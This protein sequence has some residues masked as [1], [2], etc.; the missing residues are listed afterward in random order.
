MTYHF[1]RDSEGQLFMGRGTLYAKKARYISGRLIQ[2]H[3]VTREAVKWQAEPDFEE[4]VNGWEEVSDGR[5]LERLGGGDVFKL[6]L[7]RPFYTLSVKCRDP[8]ISD[9]IDITDL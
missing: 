3:C 8:I 2:E 5:M 1:K 7:S 4:N 9:V 6:D